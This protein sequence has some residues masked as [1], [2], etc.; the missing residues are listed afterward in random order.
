LWIG[1]LFFPFLIALIVSGFR[2]YPF[3][4]RM[5]LYALP[6]VIIIL[7]EGLQYLRRRTIPLSPAIGLILMAL[8]FLKPAADTA[9]YLLTGPPYRT[10]HME[11]IKPVLSFIQMNRR[12]DDTIYLYYSSAPAFH[13]YSAQF[14]LDDMPTVFSGYYREDWTR[15]VSRIGE[16]DGSKRIWFLFS[17]VWHVRRQGQGEEDYIVTYLDKVGKKLAQFKSRGASVYLYNLNNGTQ[18]NKPK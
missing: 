15:Y 4:Q 7:A 5:L 9:R 16:L 2:F 8:V 11:E 3:S 6:A 1:L 10:H 14:G 13:Y 12:P 18:P 17:H